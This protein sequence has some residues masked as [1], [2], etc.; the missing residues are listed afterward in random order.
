MFLVEITGAKVG[1][2]RLGRRLWILN[3]LVKTTPQRNG[4]SSVMKSEHL[5]LTMCIPSES[6]FL[7]DS[8]SLSVN[9]ILSTS[10]C[11]EA[12][13]TKEQWLGRHLW[14]RVVKCL[15]WKA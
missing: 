8:V 2:D 7:W 9:Q 6:Y 10:V 14:S 11:C 4:S 5:P 1:W 12:N 3:I 13:V 15:Y